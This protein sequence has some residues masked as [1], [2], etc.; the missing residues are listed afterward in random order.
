MLINDV[1]KGS[2]WSVLKWDR[3][4]WR[5]DSRHGLQN[6]L[7]SKEGGTSKNI[8]YNYK[9]KACQKA[10]I[11]MATI[12]VPSYKS[13]F[14]CM[15]TLP[16]KCT[17]TLLVYHLIMSVNN[18]R[19]VYDILSTMLLDILY[20]VTHAIDTHHDFRLSCALQNWFRWHWKCLISFNVHVLCVHRCKDKCISEN[21][22]QKFNFTVTMTRDY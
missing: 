1:S 14:L 17:G 21:E 9:L 12:A 20:H 11:S 4:F 16:K 19:H 10:I 22:A 6:N 2:K 3:S 5:W 13:P 7:D 8:F 15:L 18:P